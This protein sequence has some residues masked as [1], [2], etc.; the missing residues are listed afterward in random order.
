MPVM[1]KAVNV[2]LQD[3]DFVII[4]WDKGRETGH[5]LLSIV[6][7]NAVLCCV[8]IVSVVLMYVF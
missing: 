8:V 3:L 1:R 6:W 5:V 7:C 4:G 2:P